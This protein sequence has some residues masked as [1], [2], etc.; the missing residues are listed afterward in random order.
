MRS[1]HLSLVA[2]GS[3]FLNKMTSNSILSYLIFINPSVASFRHIDWVQV[4][5]VYT[6]NIKLL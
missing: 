6:L 3:V 4:Q 5:I 1:I 2:T